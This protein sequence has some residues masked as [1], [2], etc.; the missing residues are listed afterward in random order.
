[1]QLSLVTL[2]APTYCSVLTSMVIMEFKKNVIPFPSIL[3]ASN[4]QPCE[5]KKVCTAGYFR[6]GG[7]L[8]GD[9][10]KK[11]GKEMSLSSSW[12]SDVS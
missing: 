1:M 8:K 3:E 5:M 11:G 4:H 6:R 10:Q 7:Q 12:F 2:C 9:G